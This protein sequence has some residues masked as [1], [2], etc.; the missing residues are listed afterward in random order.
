MKPALKKI[1]REAV[2]I[3]LIIAG[4][5]SAGMGLKGFLM[6]SRFIDGGQ[7]PR[8]ELVPMASLG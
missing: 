1:A 5:F 6:S 8:S 2:S 3:A 4:I 7:D